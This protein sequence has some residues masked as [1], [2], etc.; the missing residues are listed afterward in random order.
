M[1]LI[2]E[3]NS[4]TVELWRCDMTDV[5]LVCYLHIRARQYNKWNW[6]LDVS[7]NFLREKR[8]KCYSRLFGDGMKSVLCF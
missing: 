4:C 8:G 5:C 1:D 3:V 7:K 2:R 6:R